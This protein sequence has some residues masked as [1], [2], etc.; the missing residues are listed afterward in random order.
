MTHVLQAHNKMLWFF[1]ICRYPVF[2]LVYKDNSVLRELKTG[3]CWANTNLTE[4]KNAPSL[5]LKRVLSSQGH[6]E[7]QIQ[8]STVS[9]LYCTAYSNNYMCE[10]HSVCPVCI[11]Y[12]TRG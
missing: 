2:L 5:A 7:V 6:L 12:F 8:T 3:M 1:Y 9:F 4:A 10:F 11:S